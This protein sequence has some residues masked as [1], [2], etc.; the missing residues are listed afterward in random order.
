ML[1]SVRERK[2]GEFI[3]FS[4]GRRSKRL[5]WELCG[6]NRNGVGDGDTFLLSNWRLE[7][8]I[9]PTLNEATEHAKCNGGFYNPQ[10][11]VCLEWYEV[12]EV[13]YRIKGD[14]LVFNTRWLTL[15]TGIMPEATKYIYGGPCIQGVWNATAEDYD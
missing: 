11:R 8:H 2:Y 5:G 9:V 3:S 4:V 1:K 13:M 6:L 12:P 15:P 7:G 14:K 10:T